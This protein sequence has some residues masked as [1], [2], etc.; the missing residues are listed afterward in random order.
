VVTLYSAEH[1]YAAELPFVS[2]GSV[3]DTPRHRLLPSRLALLEVKKGR[4]GCH[5]GKGEPIMPLDIPSNQYPNLEEIWQ[6][7]EEV[8]EVAAFN[9]EHVR[10]TARRVIRG[11][12]DAC[13]ARYERRVDRS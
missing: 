1:G 11:P 5:A 7:G 2:S 6:V 4:R 3:T 9:R 13:H 12:A 10:I 8:V